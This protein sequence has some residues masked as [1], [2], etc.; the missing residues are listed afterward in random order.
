MTGALAKQ[1]VA[2]SDHQRWLVLIGGLKL[3]KGVLFVALGFALLRML[4]RDIYMMALR[5]V[6]ALRL[7]P[8]RIAIATLLSK[9]TLLNT[10]RLKQ[11]SALIFAYAALDFI[12]GTGLVLEKKWAEYFTLILTIALLPVEV[13]K[14]IDHPN[15]WTFLL[16]PISVIVVIYLGWLVRGQ[17]QARR[18][19]LQEVVE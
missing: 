3:L 2:R 13:I 11:L 8:E 14:L 19:A 5:V 17:R 15:R 7:D 16:T 10:H 1:T 18:E 6:E 12:E 4:H 9:V